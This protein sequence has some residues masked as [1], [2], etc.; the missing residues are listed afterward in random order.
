M[1][2]RVGMIFGEK[3][4]NIATMIVGRREIGGEA[5]MLLAVDHMPDEDTL[6]KLLDIEALRSVKLV[7]L[8]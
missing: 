6:A 8:G 5:V 4:I 3:G 7:R 1:I 2:G